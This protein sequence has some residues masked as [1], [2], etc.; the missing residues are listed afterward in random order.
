MDDTVYLILL[1]QFQHLVIVA[2]ICL[3]KYI[4]RLVLNVLQIRQVAG[5]GQFV[6]VDDAVFRILVHE[7]AYHVAA[8]ETGTAGNQYVTFECSHNKMI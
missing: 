6:Q 8:D 1:H 7:Q 4:V 5:V 2:D 3:D